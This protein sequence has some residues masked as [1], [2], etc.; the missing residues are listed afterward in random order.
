M[1]V[2]NQAQ[3]SFEVAG[4]VLRVDELKD[5]TCGFAIK[6]ADGWNPDS[7]GSSSGTASA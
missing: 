1:G 6:F 4:T 3:I 2:F 5:G 7:N